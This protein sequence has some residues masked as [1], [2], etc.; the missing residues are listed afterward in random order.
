MTIVLDALPVISTVTAPAKPRKLTQA[1][2]R[3]LAAVG[4]A[5]G[6][7]HDMLMDG[8]TSGLQYLP[9]TLDEIITLWW[10][11]QGRQADDLDRYGDVGRYR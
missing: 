6:L 8:L 11:A 9:L 5:A 7:R 1:Q 10:E 3:E 2:Q 4:R